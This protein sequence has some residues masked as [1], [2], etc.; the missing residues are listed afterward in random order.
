[1]PRSAWRK[2]R[3]MIMSLTAIYIV[4]TLTLLIA[5]FIAI[6]VED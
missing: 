1:M 3:P 6:A 2:G 4:G 5:G